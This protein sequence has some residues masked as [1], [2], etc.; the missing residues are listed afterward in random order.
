MLLAADAELALEAVGSAGERR[1]DVAAAEFVIGQHA[2]ACHK[3]LLYSEGGLFLCDCDLGE[4]C[5][6]ARRLARRRRD[7]E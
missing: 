7:G 1:F 3:R 4:S 2:R 6:P 5:R